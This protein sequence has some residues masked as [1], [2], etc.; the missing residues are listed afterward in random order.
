MKKKVIIILAV[1]VLI[2]VA[3]TMLIGQPKDLTVFRFN[4]GTEP[5]TLDPAIMTGVPEFRIA[6]QIF[7]GLTVYDPQTLAPMPGVAE[8]WTTS[9]DGLTYTFYL[10]KT[11]K[12]SDGTPI[13]AET[14]KYSWLRA[15]AP[16]T[17]A[18]YAY[19]LWYIKNGQ[20]YNTGKA[21]AED[22]G[23]KVVDK[24]TLQVTLEAPTPYFISLI[25][26]QTYMPTPKHV[27]DKVGNDRWFLKNNIV[28]NGPFKLTEWY[29]NDHITLVKNDKYWDKGKVKLTKIFIYA[30]ED[31]NTSLAQFEAG[32]LE[33]QEGV[34]TELM[35]KWKKKPEYHAAPYLGTYYYVVNVDPKLQKNNALLDVRVRKALYLTIRR[36]YLIDNIL[37][38][39]QIP[40]YSFV[41][42]N[43]PG[44]KG[45]SGP[46]ENIE[47][48]KK[49]LAEA[50]YPD[51]KNFPVITIL[52]NT[53]EGHKKIAEAI[54]QMWKQALNIDVQLENQEWKV[55]L[56]RE[57]K[58][59]YMICRA[60]WI[61]DYVDPNTFLDMWITGGGNNYA[62]YSNP[63]YDELIEKAKFTQDPK[64]RMA[65]FYQAEQILM[66]DLPIL[67]IYFYV[68]V[69]TLQTYVKGFYENI[70]GLHPLK[71]V[72]LIKK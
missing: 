63:K 23:I 69:F 12:W 35:E 34:P 59:D 8:R 38:A 3:A 20:A 50:G 72:Y 7:E 54:Q 65:L 64:A 70:L 11:A 28:C 14:F 41:P 1:V 9:K 36:Q 61:G 31:N 6:M 57:H 32:E 44:Y 40:A 53:S 29:P 42:P 13:D 22:V 43:M 17:A 66:T 15:L 19:Q 49:L 16:E 46:K 26:F 71:E 52:Y 58:G 33:Y 30:N 67:P 27:I 55:Y 4:N 62:N 37:K 45:Y 10:R 2:T 39:D 21:K 48:A 47:E 18:E 60:G 25:S 68:N 51:G 24:Y 5:Q 56:D